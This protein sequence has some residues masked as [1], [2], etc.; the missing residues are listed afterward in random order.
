MNNQHQSLD[1][2]DIPR[3]RDSAT[4][5]RKGQSHRSC[6]FR[7]INCECIGRRFQ[8][9]FRLRFVPKREAAL[10]YL[11]RL[12]PSLPPSVLR[13]FVLLFYFLSLPSRFTL[14]TDLLLV[15]YYPLLSRL[16]S[17]GPY[18]P[19]QSLGRIRLT[20]CL[21]EM[22]NIGIPFLHSFLDAL[23]IDHL[24]RVCY[25]V[26]YGVLEFSLLHSWALF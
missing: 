25:R 19:V 1:D 11:T 15:D 2:R 4:Q 3:G 20:R 12:A 16:I 7:V 14:F 17:H 8:T 22:V 18:T 9:V 21:R 24:L 13:A 5:T 6:A 10:Q 26:C 23:S